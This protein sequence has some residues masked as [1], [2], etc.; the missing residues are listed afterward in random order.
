MFDEALRARLLALVREDLEVRS[1]LL[2]RG[3]LFDGYHPR[4]AD[5]HSRNADEL[6]RSIEKHGWPG[7]SLVGI[8]GAEAA[9]LILQHAIAR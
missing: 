4:M 6:E 1:E 8:D 5:V 3:E 7:H 2:A 9:W